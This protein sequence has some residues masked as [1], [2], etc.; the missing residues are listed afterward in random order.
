MEVQCMGASSEFIQFHSTNDL[1]AG[2]IKAKREPSTPGE[3]IQGTRRRTT[4]DPVEFLLD[5]RVIW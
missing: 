4:L 1:T 2:S 5:H 3:Q